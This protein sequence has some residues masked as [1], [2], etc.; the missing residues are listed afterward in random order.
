LATD[1][2]LG[3]VDRLPG[4]KVFNPFKELLESRSTDATRETR[5]RKEWKSTFVLSEFG[6]NDLSDAFAAFDDGVCPAQVDG[7][8]VLGSNGAVMESVP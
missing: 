8:G 6:E 4:L 1:H 2:R 5:F 3:S 7:V